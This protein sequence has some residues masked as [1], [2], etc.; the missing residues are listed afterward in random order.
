[1][2]VCRGRKYRLYPSKEIEARLNRAWKDLKGVER[3]FHPERDLRAGCVH[4]PPFGWVEMVMHRP[5]RGRVL[6]ARLVREGDDWFLSMVCEYT[7]EDPGVSLKPIVAVVG[8]E[9]GL[10]DSNG[11]YQ[12]YPSKIK[13]LHR[14]VDRIKARNDNRLK[15]QRTNEPHSKRWVNARKRIGVL[16]KRI[17]RMREYWF[18]QQA[19][20]YAE[21]FSVVVVEERAINV[22]DLVGW[23]KFFHFLCYKLEERGGV[24]CTVPAICDIPEGEGVRKA[25]EV[26]ARYA[27]G[28]G[29]LKG[30][31]RPGKRSRSANERE[32]YCGQQ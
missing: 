16:E 6:S 12:H 15:H 4:L 25:Q 7:I 23:G 3:S 28:E 1:M 27:S 13:K 18:H 9:N 17:R 30:G 29:T 8:I 22:K 24:V 2:L 11:R 21:N 32:V 20:Y 19:L 5:L 31:Y 26:L 14:K 10:V